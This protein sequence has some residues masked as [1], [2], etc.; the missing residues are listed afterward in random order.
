M[1]AGE[2]QAKLKARRDK[3][4]VRGRRLQQTGRLAPTTINRRFAFLRHVLALAVKDQHLSRNPV[5]GITFFPETKRTRYFSDDELTKL[6]SHMEIA[7]WGIVA[8]AIETGLRREEQFSLRWDQVCMESSL[9]TLPMPKGGK[10]RYVPLSEGS[11]SILRSLESFLASPWVFPS[12]Q[13]PLRSRNAQSFVNKHFTPRPTKGRNLWSVLA[14][15]Q[16]HCCISPSD[17]RS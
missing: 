4:R 8:F 7:E 3:V 1:I 16:T 14:Y 12:P 10:T 9:I 6:H 17:G 15:P 11:K 2:I 13:N 5:S